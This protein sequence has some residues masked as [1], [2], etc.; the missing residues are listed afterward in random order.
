MTGAVATAPGR[1]PVLVDDYDA[2][3]LDLDGV[4]YRGADPV[5]GVPEALRELQQRGTRTGY[6]TNNAARTP[7]DVAAHLHRLGVPAAETDVVTSAQAGARMLADRHGDAAR[8]LALGA[9]GVRVALSDAGLMPVTRADERPVAVLQGFDPE[10]EW[11]RLSQA[12]LAIQQGAEWVATNTDPTRPTDRGLEPGNGAA[13]SALCT[14]VGQEPDIAGKPYAPLMSETLRRLD[15]T[16]PVVVG[17]RLDTDIAGAAAVGA[18]GMLVLTGAHGPSDC[19]T[20]PGPHRP[21][22]VGWSA[23]DLLRAPAAPDSVVAS[24]DNERLRLSRPAC[25]LERRELATATER[26]AE[27]C[28]QYVDAGRPLDHRAVAEELTDAITR[29]R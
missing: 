28:W 16:H 10:L 11:E 22:H 21:A 18:D 20:A 19:F 15:A 9:D 14:A 13:V 5:P 3:I 29:L 25:D 27:L 2:A 8:I 1:L 4:V 24:A 6:V 12:A 17:D 26:A 7:A 23:A